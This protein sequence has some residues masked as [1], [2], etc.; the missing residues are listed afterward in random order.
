MVERLRVAVE[1]SEVSRCDTVHG[2]YEGEKCIVMGDSV[3]RNVGTERRNMV[4][5]GFQGIGT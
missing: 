3:I 5:E 4:V 1:G 2:H